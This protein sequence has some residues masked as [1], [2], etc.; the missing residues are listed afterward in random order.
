MFSLSFSYQEQKHNSEILPINLSPGWSWTFLLAF[1]E[2]ENARQ[3][4]LLKSFW[5]CLNA[6]LPKFGCTK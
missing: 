3:E 4:T 2:G 1:L 5:H 6:R